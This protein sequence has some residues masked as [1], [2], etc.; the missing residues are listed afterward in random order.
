MDFLREAKSRGAPT[1][2]HCIAGVNRSVVT[3]AIFLVLE[4]AAESVEEAVELIKEK[5]NVASPAVRYIRF[6]E[7]YV[8]RVRRFGSGGEGGGGGGGGNGGD[9][10]ED[11]MEGRRYRKKR[12]KPKRK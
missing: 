5:R 4:G 3:L 11:E 10:E 2:V 9:K 7:R 1:L 8:E 6:A 12:D